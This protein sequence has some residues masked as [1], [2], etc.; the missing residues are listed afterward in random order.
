MLRLLK[1]FMSGN[2]SDKSYA[3]VT[4]TS[5]A[6]ALI[7]G[8]LALGVAYLKH[9]GRRNQ[10]PSL[11][12]II[13]KT[14]QLPLENIPILTDTEHVMS[15]YQLQLYNPN[16]TVFDVLSWSYG[17]GILQADKFIKKLDC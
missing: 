4:G 11:R 9:S 14:A 12:T 3:S 13:Q 17:T 5:A 7:S 6:V 2:D 8:V 15:D 1:P 16:I 10:I